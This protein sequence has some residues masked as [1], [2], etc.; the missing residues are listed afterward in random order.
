[1]QPA[2]GQIECSFG[3]VCPDAPWP[4]KAGRHA[5]MKTKTPESHNTAPDCGAL[6]ALNAGIKPKLALFIVYAGVFSPTIK[7]IVALSVRSGT[8]GSIIRADI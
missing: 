3:P 6:R 4:K 7:Y 1:M 5:M 2:R 8:L